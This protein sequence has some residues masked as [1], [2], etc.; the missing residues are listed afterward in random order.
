M[1]MNASH[2]SPELAALY[3]ENRTRLLESQSEWNRRLEAIGRDRKRAR[4][5]LDP[6]FEEQSIQREND[7][8]LDALDD[9]G[10]AALQAIRAA[11]SRIESGNYGWCVA[12]G[13]PIAEARLRAEPEADRCIACTR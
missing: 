7:P 10:R 2:P 8:T 1:G 11:L 9:R 13:S 4:G 5:P 6:D 3:E 12:C